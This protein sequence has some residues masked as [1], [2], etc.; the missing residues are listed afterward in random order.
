MFQLNA[1]QITPLSPP[2]CNMPFQIQIYRS[3]LT[4]NGQSN[5]KAPPGDEVPDQLITNV[6][7]RNNGSIKRKR[8]PDNYVYYI[9]THT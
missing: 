7:G 3:T 1:K 4:L 9:I 6:S 8:T 2:T 5:I